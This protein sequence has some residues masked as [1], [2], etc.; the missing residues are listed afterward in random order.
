MSNME[1]TSVDTTSTAPASDANPGTGSADGADAG[2]QATADTF[3]G[4][5]EQYESRVRSFQSEADRAKAEAASLRAQLEARDA[6]GAGGSGSD[7]S[8]APQ[9][10]PDTFVSELESRMT[11]RQTMREAAAALQTE[12]EFADEDALARAHEF[13]SPEA[14]RAAIEEGH[15]AIAEWRNTIREEARNEFLSEFATKYGVQIEAP[16]TSDSSTPAGEPDLGTWNSWSI[17]DQAA[18]EAANPGFTNRLLRSIN[19]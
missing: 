17:S 5:R 15:N 1:G 19:V 9:F 16:P 11:H 6:G 7:Q 18:Y 8:A 12:F 10:D 4:E 3:A 2:T 13:E 14:L